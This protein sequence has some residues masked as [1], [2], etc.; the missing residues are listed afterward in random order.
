MSIPKQMVTA[1][2]RNSMT[3]TEDHPFLQHYQAETY[4]PLPEMF[5][6]VAELVG[7]L[8]AFG[9]GPDN[10]HHPVSILIRASS[11]FHR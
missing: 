9:L 11:C 7:L 2:V 8:L 5:V 6:L 10:H 4:P 1:K 3:R